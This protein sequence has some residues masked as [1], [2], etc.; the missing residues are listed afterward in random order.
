M[1]CGVW[2]G[3]SVVLVCY[4]LGE[5]AGVCSCVEGREGGREVTRLVVNLDHASRPAVQG[6][7]RLRFPLA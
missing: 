2:H 6:G 5:C 4:V 3:H 7:H 1:G